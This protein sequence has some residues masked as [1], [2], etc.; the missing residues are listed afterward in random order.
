MSPDSVGNPRSGARIFA[1]STPRRKEVAEPPPARA[2]LTATLPRRGTAPGQC[3]RPPRSAEGPRTPWPQSAARGGEA[4]PHRRGRLTAQHPSG[5]RRKVPAGKQEA[6]KQDANTAD[7]ALRRAKAE[8]VKMEER[9]AHSEIQGRRDRANRK[10]VPIVLGNRQ[11]SAEASAAVR[12]D[13]IIKV[14]CLDPGLPRG[15]RVTDYA[16][17]TGAGIPLSAPSRVAIIGANGVGKTTYLRALISDGSLPVGYLPQRVTFPDDRTALELVRTAA[18]G[19]TPGEVRNRMAR[20]L[21]RGE[22]VNCPIP[23]LSGG[24][25]PPFLQFPGAQDGRAGRSSPEVVE[26]VAGRV[27]E[28]A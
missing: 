21:L 17:R 6:A 14:D 25:R 20:L 7:Q 23:S 22:M 5:L 15:R 28:S 3:L 12:D 1:N 27:D 4:G 13:D 24:E 18:P 10:F 11:N 9:I 8:R 16:T 26:P 19:L 2:A